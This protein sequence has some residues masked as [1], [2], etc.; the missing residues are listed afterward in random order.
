VLRARRPAL[1][2]VGWAAALALVLSGLVVAQQRA[3]PL[4]APPALSAT[5][6]TSTETAP[7]RL[8]RVAVDA[9][10]DAAARL[11]YLTRACRVPAADERA[12]Y[13]RPRRHLAFAAA[14]ET[15][16]VQGRYAPN[17]T[18]DGVGEDLYYDRAQAAYLRTQS[19]AVPAAGAS[20]LVLSERVLFVDRPASCPLTPLD[21]SR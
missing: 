17:A 19:C 7:L 5:S 16:A 11:V 15:C 2:Q 1:K 10:F 20:A 8:R 6:E 21:G 14:Q 9:Y 18:L 13:D 4:P 3:E 12:T